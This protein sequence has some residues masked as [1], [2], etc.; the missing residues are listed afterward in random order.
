LTL[1]VAAGLAAV[2]AAA[3]LAQSPP[4]RPSTA[5]KP[6]AATT[7]IPELPPLAELKATRERPLFVRSR[8]PPPVAPKVVQKEE[9]AEVVPSEEAPAELIGIVVGPE[10]TYAILKDH[11]TKEVQHL[12]KGEKI[13]D[14]SLDEIETRH[15]VLRRGNSKIHVELFDQK[16]AEAKDNEAEN[17]MPPRRRTTVARPVRPRFAQ[18]QRRRPPPPQ[19]R[20]RREP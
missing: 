19:R 17:D 12:Q 5:A 6:P 8:R 3:A 2:L 7:E 15:I 10:R 9:T 1:A 16:E 18:P 13:D 14:W 4:P 20:P 11:T